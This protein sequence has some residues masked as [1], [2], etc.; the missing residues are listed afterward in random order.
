MAVYIGTATDPEH[1]DDELLIVDSVDHSVVPDVSAMESSEFVLQR[2]A[3][4]ARIGEQTPIDEFNERSAPPSR[5]RRSYRGT[6]WPAE[7]LAV[8]AGAA[9]SARWHL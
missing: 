9:W 2:I 7:S 4:P 6:T 5:W 1:F 8:G 3:D